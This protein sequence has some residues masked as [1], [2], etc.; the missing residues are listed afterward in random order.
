[1]GTPPRHADAF[2][3]KVWDVGLADANIS[4]CSEMKD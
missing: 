4:R 3:D 1:M 2:C